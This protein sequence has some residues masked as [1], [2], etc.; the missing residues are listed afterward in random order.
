MGVGQALVGIF[1][2][3]MLIPGLP[4]MSDSVLPHYPGQERRVNDLTAGIFN[5]F[6]GLGQVLAPTY[7]SFMTETVGF[8]LTVDIVAI[9]C[10]AFGLIY[11][12]L[13]QGFEAFS[14]SYAYYR[15]EH[16]TMAFDHYESA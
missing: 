3:V 8:R 1:V 6:L 14:Q 9:L 2:A 11:L 13:G 5:S 12:V 7:G 15:Q 10:F 16:S 4:E